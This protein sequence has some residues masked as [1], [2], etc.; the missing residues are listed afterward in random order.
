MVSAGISFNTDVA[1]SILT[2]DKENNI[3]TSND[4]DVQGAPAI[5]GKF[6]MY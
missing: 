5:L 3:V 2:S 1:M 4:K 6:N